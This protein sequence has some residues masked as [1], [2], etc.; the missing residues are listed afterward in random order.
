MVVD[1][2]GNEG[3]VSVDS[4]KD[5]DEDNNESGSVSF[6]WNDGLSTMYAIELVLRSLV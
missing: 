2:T 6:E 5:L 1:K 3:N 4:S